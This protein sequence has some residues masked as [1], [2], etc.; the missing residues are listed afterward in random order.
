[1]KISAPSYISTLDTVRL[2]STVEEI[3][4]DITRDYTYQWT[5]PAF[6]FSDP[7]VSNF[8]LSPTTQKNLVIAPGLLTV[9]NLLTLQQYLFK[10]EV[11][12]DDTVSG[13]SVA[14]V[15]VVSGPQITDFA[16]DSVSDKAGELVGLF[17]ISVEATLV[18]DVSALMYEFGY[19]R[20][21]GDDITEYLLVGSQSSASVQGKYYASVCFTCTRQGMQ[22]VIL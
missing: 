18:G 3:S 19:L 16:L 4:D 12:A 11:I 9:P 14:V 22:L 6:N 5:S 21:D 2:T 7:E 10:L 17:D 15:E 8:L 1:M 20:D 13:S